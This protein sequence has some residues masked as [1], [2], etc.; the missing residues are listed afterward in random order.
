M[1]R[2]LVAASRYHD[3]KEVAWFKSIE[4]ATFE[5]LGKDNLE[6]FQPSDS[7]LA[8]ALSKTLPEQLR[9]RVQAKEMEAYKD[10]ATLTG[11]QIVHMIYDWFR[12]DAH[13]STFFSFND[14]S[15]LVWLG[16]KL[17]DMEKFLQNWD[18]ILEH[19]SYPVH[20]DCLRDLSTGRKVA[21]AERGHSPLPQGRVERPGDPGLLPGLPSQIH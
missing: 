4:N 20:P 2:N 6:R 1:V 11:R 5:E 16:D 15:N 13:M 12:T 7:Q 18:H 8:A 14:L 10:D 9:I 19:M 3:K 17:G 21:C